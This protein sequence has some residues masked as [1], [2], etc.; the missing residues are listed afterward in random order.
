M[1]RRTNTF[2]VGSAVIP[3]FTTVLLA[4]D[5]PPRYLTACAGLF[6]AAVP[7]RRTSLV[8]HHVIVAFGYLEGF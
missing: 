7:A 8:F 4:A 6:N 3:T 5:Q 1:Y 2:A